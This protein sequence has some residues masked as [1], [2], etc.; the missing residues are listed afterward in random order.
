MSDQIEEVVEPESVDEPERLLPEHEGLSALVQTSDNAD[1]S[2]SH[3][4]HLIKLPAEELLDFATAAKAGGFDMLAD[5]TAVDYLG[6]KEPRFEVVVNLLNLDASQR[7]RIRCE[8]DGEHPSI[9]SLVS[10]YPGAN[11][12][13]REVFDLMGIEFDG[14]PDLTRILMPDDWEGHPL[15]KDFGLGDVPVQFKASN[16]AT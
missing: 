2:L 8:V 9:G 7:I 5:V 10:V 4:D 15:R 16:K 3:G 1:Y 6:V 13:E 14:H 12:F 11:F